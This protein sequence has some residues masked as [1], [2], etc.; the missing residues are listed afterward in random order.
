[1]E[2]LFTSERLS[3]LLHS[4]K[5]LAR[6]YGPETAA[7]IPKRLD[8]LRFS[9]NL[10]AALNLPGRLHELKGDRAGTF[11][12]VLKHGYRLILRPTEQPPPLKPD[13][14][15]DLQAIQSVVILAV[16]DYHD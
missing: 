4:Q 16:E 9:K 5:A 3:Q 1:M 13:G 14:G 10:A 6:A 11:A 12:I 2:I 7:L 15:I 8:N